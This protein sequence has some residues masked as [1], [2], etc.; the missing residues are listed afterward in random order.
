MELFNIQMPK[1]STA[2]QVDAALRLT[3]WGNMFFGLLL[4]VLFVV[5]LLIIFKGGE[6]EKRS[7]AR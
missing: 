6:H 3:E 1:G 2:E 7:N 4:L 5:N